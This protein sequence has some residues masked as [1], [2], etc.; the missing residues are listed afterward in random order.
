M[1]IPV[2]WEE[3]GYNPPKFLDLSP[4]KLDNIKIDLKGVGCKDVDWIYLLVVRTTSILLQ[5]WQRISGLRKIQGFL[6]NLFDDQ[7]S[8][9][10]VGMLGNS[11]KIHVAG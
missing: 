9:H 10:S 1:R 5:I 3:T 6:N 11:F 7:P 4:C 2:L 8:E